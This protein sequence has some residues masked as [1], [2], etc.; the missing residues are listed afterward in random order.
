[1][2]R[3]AAISPA[4][5][6]TNARYDTSARSRRPIRYFSPKPG[7][8]FIPDFL[9]GGQYSESDITWGTNPRSYSP[10]APIAGFGGVRINF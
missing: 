6:A 7:G 8:A 3:M 5:T 1:M 10:A 9:N 4:T 2:T